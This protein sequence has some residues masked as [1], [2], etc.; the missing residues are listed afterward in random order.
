MARVLLMDNDAP[1]AAKLADALQRRGLRVDCAP[2]RTEGVRRTQLMDYDAI[3]LADN[4]P[5][6]DVLTTL[7][8]L[9]RGA[10]PPEVV[11][12]SQSRDQDLAEEAI[13]A[14]AWNF[15]A[16]P[17]SV[18]RLMVVIA[19]IQGFRDSRQSRA[20]AL[21]RKEII[22][23]AVPLQA[24]LD[25]VAQAATS[26]ANVL[27]TGE[28]GTGKELFARAVH[29]N[30]RRHGQ[31][32]IVVD[33][34]ALPASLAESVLFGHERGAFTSADARTVGLVKQADKGTLFL[35]EVGELPLAVQKV[36]F[37]GAGNETLPRRGRHP[38]GIIRL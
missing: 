14:G 26:D 28:T 35:D 18:E 15:F 24:A 33:C 32:F 37:A 2:T 9:R 23:S 20:V 22:G 21:K 19:R 6:A 31:A 16:K 27:I 11:V 25:Q 1:S 3:L 30:S 36:F 13:R 29:E 38:R 4:L 8:L 7:S 10:T 34:A 17:A 5:D 12:L